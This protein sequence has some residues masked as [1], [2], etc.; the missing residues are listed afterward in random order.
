M[1]IKKWFGSIEPSIRVSETLVV[2]STEGTLLV[3]KSP[4]EMEKLITDVT[5]MYNVVKGF[6]EV[7]NYIL[8]ESGDE[9][10]ILY[11]CEPYLLF[12]IGARITVENI[13]HIIETLLKTK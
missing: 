9:K 4:H 13:E 6:R 2:L 1:N 11:M 8:F 12:A 3:G 5:N 10:F 7:G